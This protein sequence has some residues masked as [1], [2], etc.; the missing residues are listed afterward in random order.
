MLFILSTPVCRFNVENVGCIV[1]VP[2]GLIWT[3]RRKRNE[4]HDTHIILDKR[5]RMRARPS[6]QIAR[7]SKVASR[8]CVELITLRQSEFASLYL[9]I[10]CLKNFV[11][12]SR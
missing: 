4:A 5:L 2:C 9:E 10:V 12:T 7:N 6:S 1:T 11:I 8:P 3:G